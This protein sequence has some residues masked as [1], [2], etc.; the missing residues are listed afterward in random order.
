M[1]SSIVRGAI[2][3]VLDDPKVIHSNRSDGCD[4][5]GEPF[6]LRSQKVITKWNFLTSFVNESPPT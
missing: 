3:T 5:L 1:A 6:L 2:S 4:N